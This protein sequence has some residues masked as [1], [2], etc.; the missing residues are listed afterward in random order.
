[1]GHWEHLPSYLL[2][3]IGGKVWGALLTDWNLKPLA[4]Y[5][6]EIKEGNSVFFHSSRLNLCIYSLIHCTFLKFPECS[7]KK[8]SRK[9][10]FCQHEAS[11]IVV[12]K[13]V[14]KSVILYNRY[15]DEVS[16]PGSRETSK[17]VYAISKVLLPLKILT[18]KYLE[19]IYKNKSLK[20]K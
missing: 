16:I 6:W 18:R 11:S 2:Y 15:Y 9:I 7:R 10:G 8:V 1:M 17:A 14:S 4:S 3:L 5:I 20:K 19:A 12:G 13:E